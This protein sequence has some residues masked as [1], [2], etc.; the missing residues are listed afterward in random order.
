MMLYMPRVTPLK[1]AILEAGLT[2]REI[3]ETVGVSESKLSFIV[4]GAYADDA[5]RTAIADVL[6]KHVDVLWPAEAQAA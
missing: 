3:A 1:L 4:R 5:T 6:G 2:Q